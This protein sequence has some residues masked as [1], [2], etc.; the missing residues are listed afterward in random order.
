MTSHTDMAQRRLGD[1]QAMNT[2]VGLLYE[3]LKH[4]TQGLVGQEA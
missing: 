1:Q 4:G 3:L 2:F